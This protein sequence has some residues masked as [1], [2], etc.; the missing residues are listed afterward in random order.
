MR[1]SSF[2]QSTSAASVVAERSAATSAVRCDALAEHTSAGATVQSRA[3]WCL[4]MIGTVWSVPPQNCTVCTRRSST[5]GSFSTPSA[6]A[7]SATRACTS[8][9]YSLSNKV[10]AFA[11]SMRTKSIEPAPPSAHAA[12]MRSTSHESTT[13]RCVLATAANTTRQSDS[14]TEQTTLILLRISRRAV[15]TTLG[16]GVTLGGFSAFFDDSNV[17]YW[18]AASCRAS[19]V[20]TRSATT[21]SHAAAR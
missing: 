5:S 18:S 8:S 7:S 6:F 13:T 2:A 1:A 12:T 16:A 15:A 21:Q 10:L 4:V 3:N 19:S 9:R 11:D 17:S 20:T 14:P